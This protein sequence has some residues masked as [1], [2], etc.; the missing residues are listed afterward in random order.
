MIE[1]AGELRTLGYNLANCA[2]RLGIFP[3]F[4]VNFAQA[5]RFKPWTVN[6]ED[7]VDMLLGLFIDGQQVEL[8]RLTAHVSSAF[9]DKAVEMKL[10][11]L[12]GRFLRSKISL[13]PCYNK[14]IVTD[15][16]VK[17]TAINQVMWLWGESYLLGG[18]VKRSPR[19]RAIDLGTG[20]G[21]HAILASDH[22]ESVVAVDINPR[23]IEFARF[24]S[25]LNGINNIEFTLSDLFNSVDSTCDL[26]LA[27][28][29]YAPDSAA[30]AGDNFW[31]GGL[32]GTDI[33]RRIVEAIPDRLDPAGACHIVALY[34]N[35]TGTTIR[36]HFGRWLA[37]TLDRYEVLDHTWRV[38][39]YRDELSD[40]PFTGDKS[41]WR[42][43]V[44]SLR[45]SSVSVGWWKEAAGKGIYFREDGSCAV[46]ADHDAVSSDSSKPVQGTTAIPRD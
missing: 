9:V 22:C 43:G 40:K 39:N 6:Q 16:A 1:F 31:S 20:S 45:H 17:N 13:F 37:G 2:K 27:N 4:G 29:P 12:D 15:R 3:R 28:P 24:N 34:P 26:L 18:Q 35:P 33:L 10:V 21:V 23:A 25:A 41:A 32:E 38:P 46:I 42:F 8:D 36:D 5:F 14:F 30:L 19:R 7:P 44:V 11:E